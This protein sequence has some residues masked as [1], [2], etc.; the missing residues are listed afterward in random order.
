MV[1]L[2][3]AV[4]VAEVHGAADAVLA[5][6]HGSQPA[7]TLYATRASCSD[8]PSV[9]LALLTTPGAALALVSND[10][11]GVPGERRQDQPSR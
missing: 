2:Q 9:K 6:G 7:I 11:S 3:P 1:T 8:V 5:L 10:V 4:A